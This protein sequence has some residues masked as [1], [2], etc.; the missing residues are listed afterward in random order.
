MKLTIDKAQ[1]VKK[2]CYNL[3]HSKYVTI[4]DVASVL[5]LITS[6]FPGVQFGP[7]YYR[8]LELSKVSALNSSSGNFHAQMYI[9]PLA[10]LE[11]QWWIDSVE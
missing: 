4:H 11:R 8:H 5:G 2:A 7:L 6:S 3:L 9:S 1:K 10:K